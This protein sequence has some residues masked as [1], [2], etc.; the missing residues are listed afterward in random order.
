M[1]GSCRF[2]FCC[3]SLLRRLLLSSLFYTNLLSASNPHFKY[4][5]T[6]SNKLQEK[7]KQTPPPKHHDSENRKIKKVHLAYKLKMI[8]IQEEKVV[9]TMYKRKRIEIHKNITSF[10]RLFLRSKSFLSLLP[11][12]QAAQST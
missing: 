12:H 7:Q 9:K 1:V 3:A 11:S 2:H 6:H 5:L 10:S 4:T 8:I